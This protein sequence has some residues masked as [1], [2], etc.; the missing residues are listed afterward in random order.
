MKKNTKYRATFIVIVFLSLFGFMAYAEDDTTKDKE[1]QTIACSMEAKLCP[2]GVTSVGRIGPKCEF[3]ACPGEN[4][5]DDLKNRFE[6]FRKENELNRKDFQIKKEEFGEKKDEVKDE[7]ENQKEEQKNKR[8][9]MVQNI[10]NQREE[11]KKEVE[12]KREEVKIKVEEM[13][14]KF[15]EDLTKIKDEKKK[16]SSEKILET[17]QNLNER[18]TK[19]LSEKVDEIENVLIGIESR[20]SKAEEKGLDTTKTKEEVEKAKIA[21]KTA[22]DAVTLQSEKVYEVNITTEENLKT[23]MK[24]LRDLFRMDMKTVYEKVKLAHV[25]VKNAA[26]SLAKIPKI[27]DDETN[28]E[29]EDSIDV[30]N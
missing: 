22:R 24:K 12:V 5:G 29:T 28:N 8:K 3:Q 10:K 20:I 15:K 14:S 23:E 25:A 6:N 1:G 4:R 13:R 19:N 16:I 30:E 2:D 11:F 21:I 27:D 18:L 7:F 17:I 9:E 26:V